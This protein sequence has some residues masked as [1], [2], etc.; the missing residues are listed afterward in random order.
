VAFDKAS[1]EVLGLVKVGIGSMAFMF[2]SCFMVG[3]T[4]WGLKSCCKVQ[5]GYSEESWAGLRDRFE[6]PPGV[7]GK[8]G[9]VNGAG[10]EENVDITTHVHLSVA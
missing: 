6:P 3:V 9:V 5:D 10:K 4:E 7:A 8:S 1:N 2:E